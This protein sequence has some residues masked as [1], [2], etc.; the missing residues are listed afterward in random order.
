MTK[1]KVVILIFCYV[2]TINKLSFGEKNMEPFFTLNEAVTKKLAPEIYS[3]KT[4][5]ISGIFDIPVDNAIASNSIPGTNAI[6]LITFKNGKVKY[7]TIIKNFKSYVSGGVTHY[8][9]IFS[10]DWIGYSQNRGFN[11]INIEKK[12]ARY[13]SVG[14]NFDYRIG[15]LGAVDPDKNL[16]V[17]S[18]LPYKK[19][20]PSYLRIF[21]LS[22][23][24]GELIKETIISKALVSIFGKDIFTYKGK[25]LKSYDIELK[26]IKH[27]LATIVKANEKLFQ[28]IREIIIHEDYPIAVLCDYNFEQREGKTWLINWKNEKTI[29]KKLFNSSSYGYKF[30]YDNK[31]FI[32]ES[33]QTHPS[34]YMIMPCGEEFP[35]FFGKPILL[36]EVPEFPSGGG[37]TAV[38]RNPSGFVI[39]G[40]DDYGDSYWLKKWDFT[41]AEELIEK[42]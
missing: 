23:E 39:P 18:L 7:K 26:E 15:S 11:L 4:K 10:E 17:F 9:P 28:N 3:T 34:K 27:P 40:T 42:E 21:N 12:K 5:E 29:I 16:F 20:D 2:I 41:K 35:N 32:F 31:W 6:T 37:V 38:T 8:L 22:T 19:E 24:D 25:D 36:G 13:Y 30:T 33:F 1:Y 14:G